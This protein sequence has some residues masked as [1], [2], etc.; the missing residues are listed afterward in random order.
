MRH[1][2]T[3]P[4]T[5][6]RDLLPGLRSFMLVGH[7]STTVTET[8]YRKQLRPVI[9]GGADWAFSGHAHHVAEGH[10]VCIPRD[11]NCSVSCRQR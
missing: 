4:T 3:R 5:E 9:E 7:H 8:V 11:P 2:Y 10:P 1:E 6:R